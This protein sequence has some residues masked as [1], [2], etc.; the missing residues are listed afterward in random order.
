[1]RTYTDSRLTFIQADLFLD[2]A[3]KNFADV[4]GAVTRAP[5]HDF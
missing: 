5:H 2:K 1:M 3:H 4:C